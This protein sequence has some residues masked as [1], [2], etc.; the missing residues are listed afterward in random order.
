[1]YIHLDI[2][3]EFFPQNTISELGIDIGNHF[4]WNGAYRVLE[5]S[6]SSIHNA[7]MIT[8]YVYTQCTVCIH[9]RIMITPLSSAIP[10]VC[11]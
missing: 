5:K 1:M 11:V 6:S 10:D 3:E 8:V 7:Y 2:Y 9:I 4:F